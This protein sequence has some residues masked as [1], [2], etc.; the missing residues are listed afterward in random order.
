M[1]SDNASQNGVRCSNR[2]KGLQTQC[3]SPNHPDTQSSLQ[4]SQ[5]WRQLARFGP[6]MQSCPTYF[7]QP[8]GTTLRHHPEAT[9]CHDETHGMQTSTSVPLSLLE[10]PQSRA[11]PLLSRRC[12]FP[13]EY[14]EGR[15]CTPD[16]LSRHGTLSCQD[17]PGT[18][19]SSTF[20]ELRTTEVTTLLT[21]SQEGGM[22]H[23]FYRAR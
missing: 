23:C 2:D 18:Q 21:R 9:T 15:A 4:R 3:R 1:R 13:Q 10:S 20:D 12:C 8:K 5:I 19:A 7:V 6:G 22:E 14:L 17:P 11:Q 16:W